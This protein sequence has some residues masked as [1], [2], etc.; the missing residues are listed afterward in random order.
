MQPILV[1]E[2]LPLV[3]VMPGEYWSKRIVVVDDIGKPLDLTRWAIVFASIEWRDESVDVHVDMNEADSGI[4]V[5]WLP[6]AQ[7]QRVPFGV[8][9]RLSLTARSPDGEDC[10]ICTARVKGVLFD[11]SS[12]EPLAVTVPLKIR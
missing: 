8:K 9:S 1:S 5:P 3:S 10:R 6:G 4:L 12:H 11:V 2:A 7:T